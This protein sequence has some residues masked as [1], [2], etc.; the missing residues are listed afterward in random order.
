M[1]IEEDSMPEA[2]ELEIISSTA[3]PVRVNIRQLYIPAFKGEA[4]VLENHKSYISVL[5]PGEMMYTDTVEKNHYLYIHDGFMEVD[6]NKIFIISDAVEKGEDL[7][8]GEIETKIEELS[9]IIADSSK[10]KP[11]MTEEQ[12]RQLPETLA[13]AIKERDEYQI[14]LEIIEKMEA[15]K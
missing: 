8:R 3:A 4:G 14:R 2:I 11:G 5:V 7:D 12:M 6:N 1:N 13:K 15:Q 10:L 9:Q